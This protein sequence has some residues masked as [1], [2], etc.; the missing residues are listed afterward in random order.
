M[1]DGKSKY[2]FY[3][4]G[5]MR[6]Y[7]ELNYPL[8]NKVADLMIKK[9]LLPYNPAAYDGGVS[10][11]ETEVT[12]GFCMLRD[13]NAIINLCNGI[14]LLPGWRGSLGANIESFVAFGC[15]KR[16]VE[17]V[18]NDDVTDFTLNDIDLSKYQLPYGVGAT[19]Q[20]DP[21]KCDL[22]KFE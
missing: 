12:F 22:D 14:A 3:V 20:F 18:V 2:D 1:S 10:L 21:H 9:G 11:G 4:C 19:R 6:G 15:Q 8:F 16:I 17:V 7:P 5:P 13:L